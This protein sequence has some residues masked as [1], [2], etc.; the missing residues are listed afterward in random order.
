MTDATEGS[1]T[2]DELARRTGMTVRNIRAHQSRGLVPPPAVRG[3]TGY[4][5]TE[6]AARIEL[7]RELQGDGF[8][9]ESIRR[10][11]EGAGPATEVLDFTRALREPFEDEEEP[12]IVPLSELISTWEV[13]P[14]PALLKTAEEVGLLRPL[15]EGRVEILS[16]RLFRAANEL[17]RLGVPAETAIAVAKETMRHARS[18]AKSFVG[19]FLDQIWEP[20]DKAGRP[21]ERWPEVRDAIQ[22]LRPIASEALLA[23]FQQQMTRAVDDA[24]GRELG[25]GS[26]RGRGGKKRR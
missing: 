20:F 5:G 2:I 8:N 9:L 10:L 7:I 14:D 17:A 23:I 19:L 13:E 25:S 26:G 3:R 6:H 24:F 21:E 11:L 15:D 18:V 4:Y 16:P 12:E 1:M 22:R